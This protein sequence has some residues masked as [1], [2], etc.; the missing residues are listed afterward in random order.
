MKDENN[1]HIMREFIK[2]RS[3]M[4]SIDI[5]KG[6]AIK[7]ASGVKQS[8]VAHLNLDNYR[9]CLYKKKVIYKSL[10]EFR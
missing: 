3:K 1:G 10:L 9:N 7:K 2:L 8:A 4:Y 5:L 6:N